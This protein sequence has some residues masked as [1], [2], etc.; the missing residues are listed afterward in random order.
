MDKDILTKWFFPFGT[1][2]CFII[3][4]YAFWLS[5]SAINM[6]IILIQALLCVL[7]FLKRKNRKVCAFLYIIALLSLTL[8]WYPTIFSAE[9][10]SSTFI[11]LT[12]I[13]V[14]TQSVILLFE[15]YM[16]KSKPGRMG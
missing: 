3:H 11:L 8:L 10:D 12:M 6:A 7:V 9:Y 13:L 1:F 14:I 4:V 15:Q 2:Y 5:R 16:T